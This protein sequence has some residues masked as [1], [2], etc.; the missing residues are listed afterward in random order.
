MKK[1]VKDNYQTSRRRTLIR[2]RL[3]A[4]T[5]GTILVPLAAYSLT[6]T[7]YLNTADVTPSGDQFEQVT[8]NNT[9]QVQITPNA[10]LIIVKV[11]ENDDGGLATISD[12]TIT[13]DATTD[14]LN[15]TS[16]TVGTTTTYTSD[17]LYLAP[18]TYS[19]V[20]SDVDGYTEGSWSC[21]V[22]TLNDNSFDSGE[23]VLAI[24]EQATC[25]IIN[26]DQAPTLTLTKVLINDNGGNLDVDDFEMSINDTIVLDGDPNIV[27]ANVDLTIDELDIAS[28]AEGTWSCVDDTT[29]TTVTNTLPTAGLAT[30]TTFQ[31]LP[32]SVVDCTITNN[33]LGIDLAIVKSVDDNTPN[34]GQIITFTMDVTNAGPDDAT[35]VTITDI[36]PAG[37]TYAGTISGGDSSTDTN[38]DT[39][40]LTWTIDNLPAGTPAVS[41]SFTA[42]VN[43]P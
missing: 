13:T 17:T 14:P 31:L 23:V 35:D 6:L 15:F 27:A 33:D 40:G 43:A 5:A 7:D 2:R 37:F 28:Y 1:K 38:P 25:T 30:G 18:D 16:N 32:G 20:E 11:V 24:G 39:T 42:T 3:A 19:L 4:L 41:L 36:V 8:T 29:A 9:S 21:D 10:E 26:D 12:F 22:G 34:I